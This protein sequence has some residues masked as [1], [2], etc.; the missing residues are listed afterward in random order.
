MSGRVSELCDV[1]AQS[2]LTLCDPVDCSLP[3]SS[4]LGIFRQVFLPGKYF[5]D[6]DS[7]SF[8]VLIPD[9]DA[10]KY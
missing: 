10:G 4:V 8:V 7:D 2:C 9:S 5:P 1:C 3:G 6:A